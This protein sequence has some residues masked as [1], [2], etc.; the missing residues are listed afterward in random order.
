MLWLLIGG[1]G[2]SLTWLLTRFPAPTVANTFLV[3]AAIFVGRTFSRAR[4]PDFLCLG[5]VPFKAF[6]V[7]RRWL[8]HYIRNA[9][10]MV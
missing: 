9:K 7:G 5:Q 6:R 4:S 2:I 8:E 10:R 1:K 3:G